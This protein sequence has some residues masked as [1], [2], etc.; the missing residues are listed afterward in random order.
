[1]TRVISPVGKESFLGG[2]EVIDRELK[3]LGKM[4]TDEKQVAF[5]F[6]LTAILWITRRKIEIGSFTIP[7]WS[8]LL[9]LT[10]YMH[11]GTVAIAMAL[12]LFI[13]PS[14][15][16]SGERLLE[17]ENTAKVPWGIL[18]LFGGG[19]ALAKGFGISGLSVFIGGGFSA[20]KGMNP[21]I[22][23]LSVSLLMTFLTELTSNT[24]TTQT[25]LPVLASIAVGIGVHP[26]LLML[27][28]TISASCAFMLPVATPPNA[29]VFGS[30][31]ISIK[32]MARAGILLNFVGALLV[33][34]IMYLVAIPAY[35]LN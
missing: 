31:Y 5:V 26:L 19:F 35:G 16:K 9:G 11:D 15:T 22:L 21:V 13:L 4:T 33:L 10:S 12:C 28:A 6:A 34:I 27:P 20:M 30:G 7:G 8:D 23:V 25:V 2:S 1:M 14:R 32:K 17:W 3:S 24:A 18:L 29:I